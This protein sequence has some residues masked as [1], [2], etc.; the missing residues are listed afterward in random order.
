VGEVLVTGATGFVGSHLAAALARR[1]EDMVCLVRSTSSMERLKTLGLRLVYGD[2]T[3]PASIRTHVAGKAVVYH[4]AGTVKALRRG[5]YHAVNEKGVLHVAQ[6]CAAQAEPPVLIVVSSLAAAGPSPRGRLRNEDDP[7]RPVS[8]YGRSKRAGEL[9]AEQFA[10]RVPITIVRPP[11]VFG[12]TDRSLLP[13][14]RMIYRYGIHLVPGYLPR[15]FSVIHAD[16]LAELL[17]LAAERGARLVAA[18]ENGPGKA[19]C[20]YYFAASDEHPTYYELGRMIGRALGRR[21]TLLIPFGRLVV[22][23]AAGVAE[24]IG[25]IRRRPLSL[26]VDKARDALAGS[27]AC[28]AQAAAE[29]LGYSVGATLDERFRQTAQWYRDEGWL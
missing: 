5:P 23:C 10:D 21:R 25:Q 14:F 7:P 3:D 29:Q 15:R 13:L 11:I 22:W 1:G 28:S 12:E 4:V 20:G 9:V 26:G 8:V 24:V 17:I 18:A 2:V 19:T 27:W 16:D 6:A